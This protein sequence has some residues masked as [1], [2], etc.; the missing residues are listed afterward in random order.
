MTENESGMTADDAQEYTEALAQVLAGNYRQTALGYRLGVPAALG[1]TLPEWI[2]EIGATV[3]LS[4][5]ER[6]DAVKELASEGLAQKDIGAI[7][8]VAQGTVSK[9][10]H[11]D[12]PPAPDDGEGYS[13][14]YRNAEIAPSGDGFGGD[15]YSQEYDDPDDNEGTDEPTVGD[16][17]E[18]PVQREFSREERIF[19]TMV[20]IST[21]SDA[22]IE[23]IAEAAYTYRSRSA[24]TYAERADIIES[25]H[26][27][28]NAALRR[29][30][31][32]GPRA[33]E[34]SA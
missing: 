10:L 9:D 24:R 31:K 3:K 27:R 15:M 28:F 11:A 17:D 13:Q 7:L 29:Y 5:P 33:I 21:L 1:L 30:M 20:S 25:W 32:P 16:L 12:D 6:R 14:E 18:I 26:K 34:R 22:D 23:A 4:I 8:G 19:D 2:A